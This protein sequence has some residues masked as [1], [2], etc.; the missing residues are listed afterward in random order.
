MNLEA[1]RT[2]CIRRCRWRLV[3]AFMPAVACMLLL[4][5]GAWSWALWLFCAALTTITMG[6]LVPRCSLFGRMIK[7]LPKGSRRPLLTI[8][9]GP[10]PEHTPAILNILDRH[11]LKAVFFLIGDRAEQHPHLVREIIRRGHEIANHTQ[12]HPATRF[13]AL[14]PQR[15][16]EEIS[17]C[18][19]TLSRIVPEQPPRLF[20]PPAGH[21]N[22]FCMPTAQALG[23]STMMWTARGFDGTLCD[24][25]AILRRIR[26]RLSDDGIVL[27]HENT[28][29]CLEVAEKVAE[30]LSR[31][32]A[33]GCLSA[34][35]R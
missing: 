30:M 24:T 7:R 22:P 3:A 23:L 6:T 28:P 9:D 32:A 13:W 18:Q 31:C 17:R 12:T 21:H 25:D 29:V 15:M 14:T 11:G 2:A 8:D 19:E 1:T 16:W 26:R 10:H 34:T 35:T 4:L 27:I 20:R 5:A 33:H